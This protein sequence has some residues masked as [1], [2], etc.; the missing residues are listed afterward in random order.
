MT[1]TPLTIQTIKLRRQLRIERADHVAELE[2]LLLVKSYAKFV[3][4]T[5]DSIDQWNTRI[6]TS[7]GNRNSA[8]SDGKLMFDGNTRIKY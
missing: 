6:R 1:R 4:D 7:S 2:R 5:K 8:N 3:A